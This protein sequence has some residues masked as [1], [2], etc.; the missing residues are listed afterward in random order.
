MTSQRIGALTTCVVTVVPLAE[1]PLN[2]ARGAALLRA[3]RR[4][5]EGEA[6]QRGG[7]QDGDT[8]KRQ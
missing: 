4:R 6:R 5:D 8:T 7:E 3:V 1:G 2:A